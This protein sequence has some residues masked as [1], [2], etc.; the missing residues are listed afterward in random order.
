[1]EMR[2]TST[3]KPKDT[4]KEVHR[5][6]QIHMHKPVV[7]ESSKQDELKISLSNISKDSTKKERQVGTLRK[8]LDLEIYSQYLG[9][10]DSVGLDYD[11]ICEG[12]FMK[13]PV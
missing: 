7:M 10:L 13:M 3:P 12:A 1:M 6:A 11:E 9:S 8:S 2:E 4:E 5:D